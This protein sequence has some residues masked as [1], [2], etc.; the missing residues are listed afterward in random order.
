[1]PADGDAGTAALPISPPVEAAPASSA[2]R[3]SVRAKR[4]SELE[5]E[6][7]ALGAVPPPAAPR[8]T[9]SKRRVEE[10][11]APR[12]REGHLSRFIL[13]RLGVESY[14]LPIRGV[15]EILN[16]AV[17]TAVPR[18]PDFVLGVANIRGT[19][20]PIVDLRRRIGL[21]PGSPTARP[22]WIIVRGAASSGGDVGFLVDAVGEVVD[23]PDSA[24]V[25]VSELGPRTDRRYLRGA[26]RVSG[27]SLAL[28]LDLEEL[29]R[30]IAGTV[31]A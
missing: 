24:M 4:A 13:I 19:I 10:V 17:L 11:G 2:V 3:P 22:R 9:D 28:L 6:V 14:A 31:A 16:P 21:S 15:R 18:S 12:P 29:G 20:L 30:P 8:T 26:A 7:H 1:M 23:L 5:A 27:V 25:P